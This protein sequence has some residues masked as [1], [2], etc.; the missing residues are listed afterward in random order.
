M[1]HVTTLDLHRLRYGELDTARAAEV[2]AHV[3]GCPMCTERLQAQHAMRAEFE[4]RP[5]PAALREASK[6]PRVPSWVWALLPGLMVAALALVVVLPADVGTSYE[7]VRYKGGGVEL[8]LEGKGVVDPEATRV[9]AGDR[10]QVRV[11][12]GHAGQAWVTDGHQVLG[13]FPVEAG[14]ATL[15]PFSLTLDG[16][17]G[18]EH[19]VVLVSREMLQDDQIQRILV[20]RRM[21]GVDVTY[22]EL[23]KTG[24]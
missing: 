3:D 4:V 9:H 16:Q 2:R 22:L 21:P 7:D 11:A 1:N 6:R 14:K 24:P 18:A 20:G 5:V 13:T 12:P 19:L 10:V 23:K 8:L 15:A 17:P